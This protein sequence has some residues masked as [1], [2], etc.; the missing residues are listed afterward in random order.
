MTPA[1]LTDS[2]RALTLDRDQRDVLQR[3]VID[4]ELG[5]WAVHG[6]ELDPADPGAQHAR[7]RRVQCAFAIMDD[8][9]WDTDDQRDIY[10]VHVRDESSFTETLLQWREWQIQAIEDVHADRAAGVPVAQTAPQLLAAAERLGVVA[11]M[12]QRLAPGGTFG[13]RAAEG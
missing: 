8:L 6:F 12:L 1:E 11:G 4:L 10:D 5:D 2:A 9:G 7:R 3:L 13:P